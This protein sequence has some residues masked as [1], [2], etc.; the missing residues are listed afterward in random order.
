MRCAPLIN[1]FLVVPYNLHPYRPFEL[2]KL[3][4]RRAHE[5]DFPK[6]RSGHRLVCIGN[7]LYLFGG[8]NPNNTVGDV[9]NCL[10]RELWKFDL[11]THQWTLLLRG[12]GENSNPMPVE[13]AS[14]AMIRHGDRLIIYGGTSYPFGTNMSNKVYIYRVTESITGMVETETTGDTPPLGYGQS[15]MVHKNFLYVIGG[16]DGFSY[17]CDIHRL[18]L[19]TKVWEY[20]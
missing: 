15:L 14:H 11:I 6:Q 1:W 4:Y 9:L 18:D 13:L 19:R 20:V 12:D 10:F 16:T 3:H 17:N 5:G 2:R 8:F 7:N